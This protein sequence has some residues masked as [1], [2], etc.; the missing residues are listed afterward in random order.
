MQLPPTPRH[1]T[2]PLAPRLH[3][4]SP[5]C[6]HPSPLD[7]TEHWSGLSLYFCLPDWSMKETGFF[8]ATQRPRGSPAPEGHLRCCVHQQLICFYHWITNTG[9][10]GKYCGLGSRPLPWST[11]IK[12]ACLSMFS[13]AGLFVTPWTVARQASLSME[14]SQQEYWSGSPFPSP[15]GLPDSGITAASPALVARFFIAGPHGRSQLL[16]GFP[17]RIEVML[18]LYF[19]LLSVP[20]HSV[21]KKSAQVNFKILYTIN[22]KL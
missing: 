14:C 18:T 22:T 6:S 15:G 12:R 5:L 4:A 11:E 20:Q 2:V 13:H 7:P 17:V 8:H 10:P 9:R 1:R 16:F 3:S 19:S 21:L